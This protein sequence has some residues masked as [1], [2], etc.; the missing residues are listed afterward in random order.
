[1]SK[2]DPLL[3]SY[4]DCI[5]GSGGLLVHN[6]SFNTEVD[7]EREGLLS[8]VCV[9]HWSNSAHDTKLKNIAYYYI[10]VHSHFVSSP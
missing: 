4:T 6:I 3:R 2:N 5:M 9:L 8:L 10:Q 7:P 1:M